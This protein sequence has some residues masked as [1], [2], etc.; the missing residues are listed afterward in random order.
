MTST[1]QLN[2]S[3]RSQATLSAEK[4]NRLDFY[5]PQ[6][7]QSAE[8]INSKLKNSSSCCSLTLSCLPLVKSVIRNRNHRRESGVERNC[9]WIFDGFFMIKNSF[10]FRGRESTFTPVSQAKPRRGFVEKGKPNN[11]WKIHSKIW[12][13]NYFVGEPRRLLWLRVRDFKRLSWNDCDGR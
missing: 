3:D 8:R 5:S 4:S 12:V 13:W 7:Q 2:S 6:I 1:M 10:D 11:W 9:C